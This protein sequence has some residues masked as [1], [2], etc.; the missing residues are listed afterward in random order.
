M[1]R[2]IATVALSA[3][4]V[5]G[6]VPAPASA[7][8]LSATSSSAA[9]T[10]ELLPQA[11][12]LTES[13]TALGL[14]KHIRD[15]STAGSAEYIDAQCAIDILT[16]ATTAGVSYPVY[17]GPEQ[18]SGTTATNGT[19]S[20]N[21]WAKVNLT[22][23]NDAAALKNFNASLDF[24]DEY[25]A[26]RKKENASEGTGLSTNVGLN[27]RM[28]AISIVQCDWSKA[29]TAHSSAYEVGENLAWGYSNKSPFVGWYTEEKANY[30]KRNGGQTG[31]YLNIVDKYGTTTV[32]GFATTTNG[33]LY[34]VCHEQSFYTFG[35][36][37][38]ANITYTT[39]EFRS[40]WF[41]SYFALHAYK[42]IN[43]MKA[44]AKK[45]TVTLRAKALKRSSKMIA[46]LSV[47]KAK[48][49]VT[50]ANVSANKK[51]KRFV[52]TSVGKLKVPKGTAKG[53]Y[54]VSVNV[55]AKGTSSYRSKTT[56][57]TFT[58]RVK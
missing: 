17:Q 16:G 13:Q 49:A 50:Y 22:N 20:A 25:N 56:K 6:L 31:H 18:E 5:V 1:F 43:T 37:S 15:H 26:Y 54:K 44:S 30:K 42:A 32:T 33:A 48:G 10:T 11:A 28:M 29:T 4:L 53:K 57:V 14:F 19:S 24:I 52:V 8:N 39:K 9:L 35:D 47:K 27:C 40:K 34:G 51:A 7:A 41:N 3:A 2:K 58:V 23:P 46:N 55:T 36:Y 38:P 21:A 45:K 12:K